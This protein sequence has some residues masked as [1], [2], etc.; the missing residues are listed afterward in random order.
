[1]WRDKVGDFIVTTEYS[2]IGLPD[3]IW[4]NCNI[5]ASGRKDDW[6]GDVYELASA[7]DR[8]RARFLEFLESTLKQIDQ[9]ME[10]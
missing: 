1:M 8:E 4:G 2:E 6:G 7:S 3:D 10:R 9:R 5:A